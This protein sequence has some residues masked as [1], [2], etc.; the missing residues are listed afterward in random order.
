[1]LRRIAGLRV[2]RASGN[3]FFYIHERNAVR[4]AGVHCES[5]VLNWH[6]VWRFR[7]FGV[8]ESPLDQLDSHQHEIGSSR[9][10]PFSSIHLVFSVSFV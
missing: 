1:M 4:Y 10:R 3:G 6:F 2:L 9:T 8:L 5:F 7:Y